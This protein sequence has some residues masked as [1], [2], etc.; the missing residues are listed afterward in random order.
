M[1]SY[2]FFEKLLHELILSNQFVREATFSAES[3]T[4]SRQY[5]DSNQ[6]HIFIAGL[7][8]SGTTILLNKIY[9]T[10]LFAS[11]SY[12][13]MP[14][15]LAPNIWAKM[16]FKSNNTILS[17]R[18]HGDGIRISL[19]SPEA[20]EEVFWKTFDDK[21]KDSKKKFVKFVNNVLLRHD[22]KRYLSKNNQNIRRL[23]VIN[24]I[25]PN[26]LIIIPFRDPLQHSY[27][28]FRQHMNF[29]D[30]SRNDPFIGKYMKLIGHTEFGSN[31]RPIIQDNLEYPNSSDPNHWIEQWNLVYLDC[32]KLI[33][34][35]DMSN[36]NFLS[37]DYLCT[38]PLTWKNILSKSKIPFKSMNDG[39]KFKISKKNIPLVFDEKQMRQAFTLHENLLD[40]SL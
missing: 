26:A 21:D 11:L 28:L 25:Y 6:D 40:L 12:T 39:S 18:L 34:S 3:M 31:Y 13:D 36:I 7:A 27:S 4:M 15:I 1:K 30:L 8:R 23:R 32:L 38:Q 19:E 17:D 37:Y 5:Y 14:F 16:N 2:S 29:I 35:I 9:E 10:E 24:E 33:R 22:K 20:F